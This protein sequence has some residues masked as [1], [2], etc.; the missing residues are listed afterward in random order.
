MVGFCSV[1]PLKSLWLG[2]MQALGSPY[3]WSL[4]EYF[5][6][7]IGYSSPS[8]VVLSPSLS[9]LSRKSMGIGLADFDEPGVPLF[10]NIIS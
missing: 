7:L 9:V 5:P 8:I 4:S 1:S 2:S 10:L 6:G 3:A